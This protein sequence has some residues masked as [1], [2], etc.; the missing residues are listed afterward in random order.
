MPDL[1]GFGE[2]TLYTRVLGIKPQ[3]SHVLGKH[4]T[5]Q[6]YPIPAVSTSNPDPTTLSYLFKFVCYLVLASFP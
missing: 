3:S 5:S 1:F 2:S 4:P 6:L